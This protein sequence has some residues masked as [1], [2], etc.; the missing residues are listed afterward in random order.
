MES[1][2]LKY[3][4][5]GN[6]KEKCRQKERERS[7]IELD[8]F[9]QGVRSRL[10]MRFYCSRPPELLTLD[11]IYRETQEILGFPKASKSTVQSRLKKLGFTCKLR[12]KK[13]QFT[14]GWMLLQ[15]GRECY[16]NCS[17]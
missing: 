11:E 2:E 17:N 1:R 16:L 8:E 5:C 14:K 4:T 7:K 13:F 3:S 6:A 15:I 10:V 9:D 12:N